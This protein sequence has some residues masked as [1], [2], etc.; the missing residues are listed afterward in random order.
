ML[1]CGNAR[2]QPVGGTEAHPGTVRV[3]N[4]VLRA[5]LFRYTGTTRLTAVG[6]ATRSVY[7]FDGPGATAIVDGRDVASIARIPMLVRA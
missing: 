2:R 6:N 5:S 1:C 7:R 4:S 3:H